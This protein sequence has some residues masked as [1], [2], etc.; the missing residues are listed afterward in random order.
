[1]KRFILFVLLLFFGVQN[2]LFAQ[3]SSEKL[4]RFDWDV[5]ASSD[6]SP[7]ANDQPAYAMLD[8]DVGTWWHSNYDGDA[9]SGTGGQMPEYFVLDM[10]NVAEVSGIE[11]TPRSSGTNGIVTGY[12]IYVSETPFDDVPTPA[13]SADVK[14][15]VGNRTGEVASGTWTNDAM[16]KTATFT[17]T[18]GRYILFVVTSA[19]SDQTYKYASCAEF[20]VYGNY[21]TN[22][23]DPAAV[24]AA[25]AE[26]EEL[27]AQT[28]VGYPAA[29]ATARTNLQKALDDINAQTEPTLSDLDT[30]VDAIAAYKASNDVVLPED[31]KAYLIVSLHPTNNHYFYMN[32]SG[33]QLATEERTSNDAIFICEQKGE[34]FAFK[35]FETGYYLVNKGN[36]STASG[37]SATYDENTCTFRFYSGN[38]IDDEKAFG[39]FAIV[40]KV[41]SKYSPFTI[42]ADG[43]WNQYSKDTDTATPT[44]Q[45]SGWSTVQKLIEVD[46]PD[47]PTPPAISGLA[48]ILAANRGLVRLRSNRQ[49]SVEDDTD[50]NLHTIAI[51]DGT[52]IKLVN[53]DANNT[54]DAEQIWKIEALNG[55]GYSLRSM[56]SGLYAVTPSQGQGVTL[57]ETAAPFYIE[58]ATLEGYTEKYFISGT[59]DFSG[60]A[61]LHADK[62][63]TVVGWNNTEFASTWEIEAATNVDHDALMEALNPTTPPATPGLAEIL[64]T[65]D[66]LV[67]LYSNVPNGSNN[68]L[69]AIPYSDKDADDQVV[70]VN[71][72]NVKCEDNPG[73]YSFIWRFEAKGD[74]YTLRSMYTG[75]WLKGPIGNDKE[76][77]VVNSSSAATTYYVKASEVEGCT[78]RFVI[79]STPTFDEGTCLFYASGKIESGH[80]TS[81]HSAWKIVAAEDIFK[82]ENLEA[83]LPEMPEVAEPS[84][85]LNAILAENNGLVRLTSTFTGRDGG[86][87]LA[88]QNGDNLENHPYNAT[89]TTQ[90]WQI[91]A[92]ENGGYTLRSMSTAKYVSAISTQTSLSD[93]PLTLYIKEVE[94][95]TGNFVISSSA[96]FSGSTCLMCDASGGNYVSSGSQT[97]QYATWRI[98]AAMDVDYNEMGTSMKYYKIVSTSYENHCITEMWGN[99]NMKGTTDNTPSAQI[100]K[101]T[102]RDG[103]TTI[104]SIGS[105]LY[106]QSDPGQSADFR[107]G[108]EP[109]N[110]EVSAVAGQ[111]GVYTIR[112]I[113]GGS[114]GLHESGNQ[115]NRIVSWSIDAEA[116]KWYLQEQKLTEAQVAQYEAQYHEAYGQYTAAAFLDF[117]SDAAASQL[118]SEYQSMSDEDLRAAMSGMATELQ[119]I[120]V[121]VKNNSWANSGWEK[122]FRVAKYGAFSDAAYWAGRLKTSQY[123]V[124]NNP[125][126]IVADNGDKVIIIVGSDIPADAT[127]KVE[128]RTTGNIRSCSSDG[129]PKLE[130]ELRK[131][132]N[133]LQ[134][135]TDG[136]HFY[137]T[138]LSKNGEPIA[139]YPELDIH[140]SGGDVQGY[141]NI[142]KH[143]ATDWTSMRNAGLFQADGALNLLGNYVQLYINLTAITSKGNES[144]LVPLIELFDWYAYTELD[145]LGITA[146]PAELKDLPGADA[147][148]D[149]YPKYVNNHMLCIG[150]GTGGVMHGGNQHICMDGD[151]TYYYDSLKDR[152]SSVWGFT[153]EF[154]H[155]NQGAIHLVACTERSNNLF[156]N[157]AVYKGGTCTSRGE[158]LN[159]MQRYMRNG[160]HS[161]MSVLGGDGSI[162]DGI[163]FH[164]AYMWYQL[165]LYYHAAGNA[166]FF[167][168]KLFKLLRENPIKRTNGNIQGTED[169]LHF[170]LMA[171]EAAGEDLT[172]FFEYW[173][174][175]EPVDGNHVAEYGF[176]HTLYT[177]QAQIDE[178]KAQM[179]AYPKK[180]NAAMMFIEDRAVASY[181]PDGTQKDAYGKETVTACATD[182]AGAQY[183]AFDRTAGMAYPDCV[184]YTQDYDGGITVN[185]T[186]GVAGVKFY[187][188]AG[189]LVYV[190]SARQI[191]Y[192]TN[193]NIDL[194]K[195]KAALT[196]G[197][198]IPLY[199]TT[200]NDLYLLNVCETDGGNSVCYIKGS[201][202]EVLPEMR[203]GNAIA[204]LTEVNG[205][206]PTNAPV[207]LVQAENVAVGTKIY[208]LNISDNYDYG[209]NPT[210]VYS[211]KNISAKNTSTEG[212]S[213]ENITYSDRKLYEGWNTACF[214]FAVSTADLGQGA[215]IEILDTK[216]TNGET[217]YFT[218]VEEVEA[219]VPCLIYVPTATDNWNFSKT[220]VNMPIVGQP[221]VGA[222]TAFYMNGSFTE[223]NIG[224]GHYKM[225]GAG[226]AF[227]ITTGGGKVY[228]FRAYVSADA[229]SGAS[230]LNVEHGG[231]TTGITTPELTPDNN[232][233]YDLQGRRITTP[234][235]GVPYILNGRKIIFK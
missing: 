199:S 179:A 31:G 75:Q 218:S 48:E 119:D 193:L 122:R 44:L 109:T 175:F 55:G 100:W 74:G 155:V 104:Q 5:Q 156:A 30:L 209:F 20:N 201:D 46:N 183:S 113:T 170:A 126:G 215:R 196:S 182:L 212:Y 148:E 134:S 123:G 53:F 22:T 9:G 150:T 7:R 49:L 37:H 105:K 188:T 192:P 124:L 3:S 27:L 107:L 111:S 132:V 214:P 94:G 18:R 36:S 59:A 82:L 210:E 221:V 229:Q 6:C 8:G 103:K 29:T 211:A 140:V 90:V 66:G 83:M 110:F 177:T 98:E 178:V 41:G 176:D 138:Y 203:K 142:K 213:A 133:Y 137:I 84:A 10:K 87:Y 43:T 187:N 1:M 28:G 21:E 174:F 186:E 118:K 131:G 153:H 14:N 160:T 145:L 217:L 45:I 86:T 97:S 204:V 141:F 60:Y 230:R 163:T 128:T 149:L 42:N 120:A 200:D 17:S 38:S 78:D 169:Y 102:E 143:T 157:V 181:K 135:T 144:N 202:K 207:S 224:A 165:Y 190:A 99:R 71:G 47:T 13:S 231:T 19:S 151:A 56:G 139:K 95:S 11:Y 116:S 235:R 4:A 220:G 233:L 234:K 76:V 62:N 35:N 117:F 227:G 195:T 161:W 205:N 154:G 108:E 191:D 147:Y 184:S 34:K 166:P 69:A 206:V 121:K 32:E 114:R 219:G 222:S 65:N 146:A 24:A 172:D 168:Q 96:D 216:N 223:E 171:C 85:R 68:Y 81:D 51:Q 198:S 130:M 115:D 92:L 2:A 185:N 58:K 232:Q 125:T 52:Q 112:S 158:N 225:N 67:Y 39:S 25:V 73:A 63:G 23:A 64:N 15:T 72:N 89:S 180:G 208:H 167:Y 91:N 57:S 162:T 136:S 70:P 228:P 16:V 189:K 54:T 93:S 159:Q 33:I 101:F 164:A 77:T 173:G 152:G 61:L 127:L 12:K 50:S 79:S 26:A 194:S 80:E 88:T 197:A 129:S 226:T 106:I 40:G